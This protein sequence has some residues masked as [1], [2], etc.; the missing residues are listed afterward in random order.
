M[1]HWLQGFHPESPLNDLCPGA[2]W[3]TPEVKNQ[4]QDWLKNNRLYFS[5][6]C[7]LVSEPL[8]RFPKLFS[9][10]RIRLS[11]FKWKLRFSPNHKTPGAGALIQTPPRA[12]NAEAALCNDT[13]Q[14]SSAGRESLP[15]QR[16][17]E[18]Q[19]LL[20]QLAGVVRLLSC[21]EQL[22]EGIPTHI[23][24]T[25]TCEYIQESNTSVFLLTV[26]A[27]GRCPTAVNWRAGGLT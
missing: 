9:A 21:V 13:H 17:F 2:V 4:S 10:T 22:L 25:C 1:P 8:Q 23:V 6:L 11:I 26:W 7:L 14:G 5:F 16:P 18:L 15:Q 24:L 19:E 27:L 12:H 3:P 20:P